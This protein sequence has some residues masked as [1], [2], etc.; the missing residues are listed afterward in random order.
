MRVILQGLQVFRKIS[1][2]NL[3]PLLI[4]HAKIIIKSG[5]GG[6]GCVS[7]R[8]EKYVPKGGPNGGDG[9]KGGNVIFKVDNSLSTLIDFKYKRI[10]KAAN[11]KHGLGGDKT[12]KNGEDTIIRVPCGSIIKDF[13]TGEA[14]ADLTENGQTFLVA[15]GG[16]G[17]RGN[18][19]FATP[20]N[21]APRFAE[22]GEK[23][24]EK[25]IEIELKLIADA[26]LVGLPNSGKS[27]LIS[28]SLLL[29]R[30]SLI[31][32]SQLYTQILESYVT[33]NFKALS[34]LIFP[35]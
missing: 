29:N 23:S 28:K 34:W 24:F 35:V 30:R 9:G 21:Q 19:R 1:K 16:K 14:L 6:N 22:K 31:I 3:L 26:G 32:R 18:A 17:G 27:T 15:K 4:D 13:F 2:H 33:V 10:Y 20:T 12:G 8:R 5:D 25:E 7:F 11:G